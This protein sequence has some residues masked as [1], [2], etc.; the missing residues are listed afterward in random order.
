MNTKA[1]EDLAHIK[2]MMERSSRFISLSGLS[3][4]GAGIIGLITGITAMYL[5]NDYFSAFDSNDL[6]VYDFELLSKLVGLGITALFLAIFF[7][8]FFTIRKSKHLGLTIWTSTTKKVLT[9]LFVPLVV[10]GILVLALL[11]YHLYG[12]IAGTTLIFYG[13]ALINAEKHTY[14]DIKYL[15]LLEIFLGCIALFWIG[16]GLIFWTI[17]FGVLHIIYGIILHKKYK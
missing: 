4:V 1:S 10:G 8:C 14:S 12:L 5:T 7:G 9:H 6:K 16:K 15:G 11:Q 17:G 3:G 2:E 13:L